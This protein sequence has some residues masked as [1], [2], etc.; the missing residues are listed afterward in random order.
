[1][2]RLDYCLIFIHVSFLTRI[3]NQCYWSGYV[4]HSYSSI[5]SPSFLPY[6]HALIMHQSF[7]SVSFAFLLR[8]KSVWLR[9]L[10]WTLKY[11]HTSCA[12][13]FH[14]EMD[15]IISFEP[16]LDRE[17]NHFDRPRLKPLHSKPWFGVFLEQEG[18]SKLLSA[19]CSSDV[20]WGFAECS[21]W[22][23]PKAMEEV[24]LVCWHSERWK[25]IR[26]QTS[27]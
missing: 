17:V 18:C 6:I 14:L 13:L 22:M 3:Q 24:C 21:H 27:L 20:N 1:M 16:Q 2:T 4:N 25:L 19:L 10:K 23:I 5:G 8:L 7:P 26:S 9:V 12:N 15:F 11:L